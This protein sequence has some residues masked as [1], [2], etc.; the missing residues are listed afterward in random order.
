MD[1]LLIINVN[2]IKLIRMILFIL[3]FVIFIISYFLRELIGY[4][5]ELVIIL[6]ILLFLHFNEIK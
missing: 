2:E 6:K 4:F 5:R 3:Y 1:K